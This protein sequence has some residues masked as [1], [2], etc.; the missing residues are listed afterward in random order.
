[1]TGL[2]TR[3]PSGQQLRCLVVRVFRGAL[4]FGDDVTPFAYQV[5]IDRQMI[6]SSGAVFHG[7]LTFMALDEEPVPL[8]GSVE[9][10]SDPVADQQIDD[11]REAV[12]EDNT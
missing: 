8:S 7:R 12:V 3:V 4:C 6:V 11:G 1:M 2:L 9:P 10:G 5:L